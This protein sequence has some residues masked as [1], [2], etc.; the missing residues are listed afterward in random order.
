MRLYDKIILS[1]V[2]LFVLLACASMATP[3]GGP[4][5][6]DPPVLMV[7]K[8]AIG[9]TNVKTGKITLDFDENIKLVNAF[10]KV[11]VS[12][13]QLQMP[14]IKSSGKRVTVELVDTL[15]PGVTYSIDFGDA[16]A[17]N[18]EGN[19]YEN[20]AYYFSTG[21]KVDTLAVSGTVVNAE[22]LEPIKG[23]I[24]GLHSCLDDSAFTKLPFE[25][26]SRTDSKGHFVIKGIAPGNYRL[27]A[28]NEANQ[29]YL[30]DQKSEMIAFGDTH[31][32]P[33]ATPAIRPDTVWRDSVTVD[34][35][36]Y[37]PYTRF[38]PDD[39]VLRAFKENFYAQYLVKSQ[40]ESHNKLMLYFAAPNDELPLIEGLGFENDGAFVL[41]NSVTNDTITLWFKD[42]TVYRSDTLTMRVTY[43]VMDDSIG[44]LV[45]RSD[46]IY[47]TP[48]K[49]WEK[50]VEEQNERFE[51]DRKEFLKKEK[52]KEGYDENNP[53]EYIPETEEL[54]VRFF[55]SSSM[56][57]NGNI[58][59][60]FDEPLERLD[61]LG[62]RLSKKVDTLWVPTDF[63][64]QQDNNIRKYNL[65]AEWRPGESYRIEA[66]SATFKGIYGGVS[67]KFQQEMKFRTFDEY[68]VL[69]LN[70][71]GTGSNAH[72]QLLNK[73]EAVVQT[74]ITEN[75]RCA[76]YFIKPGTYYLRL[77]I[78][79]NGNGKWDT[80]EYEKGLQPEKV[81]YYDRPL[82]LRAL[83]EY[84]QDDWDINSP[85]DKQKPLE[86]TKQKPDKE[87]K[88][89]NRNAT[90]KF[91]TKEKTD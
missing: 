62:I 71:P 61:T 67:M 46:T 51:K 17:D 9:A 24:V 58:Q 18:N 41:E 77:F 38:Q 12:P 70:I 64:L 33:F 10:E 69:Y 15:L 76:F 50:V 57:V 39:I 25:R 7:A 74:E 36:M 87:R 55:G 19:P 4:Y 26:V 37:V 45:D 56:D 27:Y 31:V 44:A 28:L 68:A 30:F 40:R 83:F 72:V 78:D 8:P 49:R 66:D 60:V 42:S 63:V 6:E 88:K 81:F 47:A 20:F 52:R 65:Y 22:N 90:R 85:L 84:S 79:D 2:T 86:I 35:V 34:S 91:K 73:S 80:G 21:D 59:F 14:E 54:K 13:P 82:E 5:D 32:S 43:K 48:K 1:T 89:M 75:N 23:M 11:I 16:I 29:N 53:P 3:D